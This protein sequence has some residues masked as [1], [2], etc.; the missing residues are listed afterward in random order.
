MK[1]QS[2][3]QDVFFWKRL[4]S[5]HILTSDLTFQERPDEADSSDTSF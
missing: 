5:G 4:K 1:H 2:L 3:P